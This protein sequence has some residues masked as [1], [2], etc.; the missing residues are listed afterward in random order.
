[1]FFSQFIPVSVPLPFDNTGAPYNLSAVVTNNTFDQS[2]YEQYSPMFLPIT[3]AV[4]YGGFFAIYP[5]AIVHTFLWYRHDITRQCRRSAKDETDIHSYLMSKYREVPH[6]WFVLLGTCCVVLGAVA[7][8]VCHTGLP[9]W[10]FVLSLVF[11]AVFILPFGLIQAITNQQLFLN[12]L[13]ELIV[14]CILPGR[15]VATM[16]FKTVA[17]D[18]TWQAISFSSDLKF[19]HYLKI[20]PRLMFTG[21]ISASIIAVISGII[22]QEWALDNI[23][24]IC[25]PD[26]SARFTCPT[27]DL[28]NTSSIL[29]GG[30]GPKRLFAAGGL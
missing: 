16:I 23:H 10:A 18:S 28:F 5:A 27:L 13:S 8:E 25:S 19:G 11:S 4:S 6:W 22:A 29:W 17:A 3:Y 2:K 30:I 7:I 26:Q 9:I 1:M 14:G 20:P 24:D 21:Q 12:V 15:P